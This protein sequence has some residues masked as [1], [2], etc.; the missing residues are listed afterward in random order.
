[1]DRKLALM[2]DVVKNFGVR[3]SVYEE[4]LSSLEEYDN[5]FRLRIYQRFDIKPLEEFLRSL[6][7]AGI[8]LT[9]DIY[10]CHYCFFC[11]GKKYGGGG[12]VLQHRSV[13]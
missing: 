8:Y 3:M 10:S 6:D 2:A 11:L 5:G 1:M 7:T 12:G 4:P 13:A 9:E